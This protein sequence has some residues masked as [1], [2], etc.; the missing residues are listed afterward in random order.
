MP[1]QPDATQLVDLLRAQAEASGDRGYRFLHFGEQ[2]DEALDYQAL[3]LKARSIAARLEGINPGDRVLLLYPPCIEYIA[4]FFGCLYRGAIPVPVFPPD[5]SRFERTLPRLLAIALNAKPSVALTTE[6]VLPL[7][8]SMLSTLAGLEHLAWHATDGWDTSSADAWK[9]PT[10]K[11]SDIAFLQ[12]TSGSTADPKGVMV[13]HANILDNERLIERTFAHHQGTKVVGWLPLYHDMGLIG[14]VLQPLYLGTDCVLMSPISFLKKP[15]RWLQAISE[16]R[17]TTSGGP[18]FAYELCIRK[19]TAEDRADLDL[20][21]WEVA[22]NGAEPVR[23]ETLE[24]FVESFQGCGFRREAWLPCYGLAE[25]TLLV[26]GCPAKEAPKH[27]AVSTDALTKHRV[28]A[29]T[30]EDDA[31]KVVAVGVPETTVLIVHPETLAPVSEGEVGEIWVQNGSVA[32]GYWENASATTQTF[33]ATPSAGNVTGRFLR[34]GDFGFQQGGELYIAGRM[35]DVVILRGQN[36]H[37]QDLERIVEETDAVIR[38]SSGAA[39]AVP[40]DREDELALVFEVRKGTD[41]GTLEAL[42]TKVC[43]AIFDARQLVVGHIAFLEQGAIPKTSSGKIQRRAC[44]QA[45]LDDGLEPLFQKHYT[46]DVTPEAYV[47]PRDELEEAL[48]EIWEEVL[49]RPRI[50]VQDDFFALGGQSV[51]GMQVLNRLQEAFDLEFNVSDLF[52][53]GRTIEALAELVEARLLEEASEE[54]LAAIE[55]EMRAETA[56]ASPAK[57]DAEQKQS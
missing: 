57:P 36:H 47:A 28:E 2:P 34:T 12:Y 56:E 24:R 42:A 19:S 14:N 51:T 21:S 20:S 4:A 30:S 13:T 11:G 22:Y 40:G 45:F 10:V 1:K 54:E 27:Q 43:T 33:Q 8:T 23:A 26:S 35:K 41:P 15:V 3:D 38:P 48:V 44:R 16:H 46:V 55:A 17:G 50:G 49:D 37:P 18:N 31:Q 9:A 52:T 32:Q 5:L 29:P 25:A 39:F 7:C 6:N 53:S